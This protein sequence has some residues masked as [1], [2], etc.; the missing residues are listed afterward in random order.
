MVST[1]ADRA[2][3]G[4]EISSIPDD[5]PSEMSV[6]TNSAMPADVHPSVY[7]ANWVPQPSFATFKEAHRKI[8]MKSFHTV[9][10]VNDI[11]VRINERNVCC[12]FS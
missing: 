4:C 12:L 2:M 6:D 11:Q 10:G 3:E 5:T 1:E 9:A 8:S 7:R